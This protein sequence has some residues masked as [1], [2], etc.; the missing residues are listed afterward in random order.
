MALVNTIL[1]IYN[2]IPL[3]LLNLVAPVYHLLPCSRKYG[4]VFQ[5]QYE[6]LY[7][8]E[9]MSKEQR[10]VIE[11]KM[12]TQAVRN[13]YENVPYYQKMFE[14]TPAENLLNL[15]AQRVPNKMNSNNH[16]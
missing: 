7:E 16:K 9:K 6:L 8:Q 3:E 14:E 12:F 11:N 15:K 4:N 10:A 13:A 1:G 2:K 5:K